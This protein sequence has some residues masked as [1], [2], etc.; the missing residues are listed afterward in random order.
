MMF[1]LT[2]W[3]ASLLL[4]ILAIILLVTSELLP[5]Y[6]K[7]SILINKKRLRNAA[8]AV[9]TLFL[10]TVAIRIVDIILNY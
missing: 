9:S 2:L 7:V 10:I 3:D 6:G 5:R 8:A 4:A 1:P